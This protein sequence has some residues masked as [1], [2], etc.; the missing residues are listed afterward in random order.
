MEKWLIGLSLGSCVRDIANGIVQL[1]EVIKIV[2]GTDCRTDGDWEWLETKYSNSVWSK[3]PEKA[4][5]LL[6]YLRAEGLIDQPRSRDE[7]PPTGV[8]CYWEDES[9][10]RYYVTREKKLAPNRS[11][12]T[13]P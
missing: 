1:D 5:W 6:W 12:Y 3:C 13:P 2:T 8:S 11:R 10:T 7:M 9:G 4:I